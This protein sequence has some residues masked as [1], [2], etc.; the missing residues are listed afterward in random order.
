M[1]DF[2]PVAELLL[3]RGSMLLL[4]RVTAFSS[5]SVTCSAIPDRQAWYASGSEEGMPA[6]IGIELMAQAI[7][8]HAAL[9]ARQLETP[10]KPGALLGTRAYGSSCAAF[11]PDVP[12][13]IEARQTFRDAGGLASYDCTIGLPGQPALAT[14]A[15][16][17]FE[18]DDFEQFIRGG[19]N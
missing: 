8:A 3:H 15:L 5:D 16:T 11:A 13:Q 14:A 19:E 10:P 6:W 4:H 1:S 12:L 18:P 2:P 7:A 9:L 17:V